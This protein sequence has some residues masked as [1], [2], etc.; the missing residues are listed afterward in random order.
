MKIFAMTLLE[1]KILII[2]LFYCIDSFNYINS[3]YEDFSEKLSTSSYND[4]TII[5]SLFKQNVSK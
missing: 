4:V 2:V 3:S 5:L 1:G